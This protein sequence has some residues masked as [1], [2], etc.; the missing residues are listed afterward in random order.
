MALDEFIYLNFGTVK[1][2]TGIKE[3][4]SEN[5]LQA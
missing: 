2:F 4:F 5:L 3:Q 1:Y